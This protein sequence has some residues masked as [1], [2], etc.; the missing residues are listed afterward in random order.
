MELL[1][2]VLGIVIIVCLF[3]YHELSKNNIRFDE[4]KF[5]FIAILLFCVFVCTFFLN[6]NDAF[7]E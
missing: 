3:E 6:N 4:H 7:S 5:L 1:Q 2:I